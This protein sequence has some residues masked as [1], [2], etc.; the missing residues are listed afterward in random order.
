MEGNRPKPARSKLSDDFSSLNGRIL[1][2]TAESS[3]LTV[4]PIAQ[5]C[6]KST[7]LQKHTKPQ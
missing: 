7:V 5:R 4:D 2:N 1:K 3:F 6:A